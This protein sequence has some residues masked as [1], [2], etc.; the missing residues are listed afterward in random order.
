MFGDLP[1]GRRHYWI[2]FTLIVIVGLIGLL[3]MW[4]FHV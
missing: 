3:L 2:A 4:T 1:T